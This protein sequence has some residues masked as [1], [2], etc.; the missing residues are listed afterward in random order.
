MPRILKRPE[1]DQ[2]AL[3]EV[4]KKEKL[5]KVTLDFPHSL[6]VRLHC[7]SYDMGRKKSQLAA[8]IIDRGLR[9]LKADRRFHSELPETQR[10]D[11]EAA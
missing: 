2:P 1:P 11:D 6:A 10:Q 7:V 8:E 4:A 5:D 9:V 3:P